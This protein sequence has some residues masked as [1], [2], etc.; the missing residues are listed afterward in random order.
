MDGV[1]RVR[2]AVDLDHLK[3]N[4]A[5]LRLM[6]PASISP[7]TR[8]GSEEGKQNSKWRK[9]LVIAEGKMSLSWVAVSL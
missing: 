1:E 6:V 9:S 4:C 7:M 3:Q 8:K 2:V 5:L